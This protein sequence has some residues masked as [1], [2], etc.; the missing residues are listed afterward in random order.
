[1]KRSACLC[2][3]A[4]PKFTTMSRQRRPTE[5]IQSLV[6]QTR[7]RVI[8]PLQVLVLA[9]SCAVVWG[10]LGKDYR[11]MALGVIASLVV[12]EIVLLIAFLR[13]P[14]ESDEATVQPL[15]DNPSET[16]IEDPAGGVIVVDKMTRE[17][18]ARDGEITVPLAE[19]R[20]IYLEI[21]TDCSLM[22]AT[23]RDLVVLTV[24]KDS[25]PKERKRL[26]ATA[27]LLARAA[28]IPFDEG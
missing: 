19:A 22:L 26:T 13:Q 15:V 6:R 20:S 12:A 2:L 3:A 27:R 4:V 23:Q 24:V 9:A 21:D 5:H 17:I 25:I 18:R 10:W 11:P 14:A 7:L 8:L 1:M 16:V 28:A